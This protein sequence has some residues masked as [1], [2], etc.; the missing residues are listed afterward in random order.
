MKDS[1]FSHG[2]ELVTGTPSAAF[3]R[4]TTYRVISDVI[5][6]FFTKYFARQQISECCGIM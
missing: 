2:L 5:G 3:V 6:F 4:P 1:Q